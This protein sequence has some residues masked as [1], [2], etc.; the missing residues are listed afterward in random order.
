MLQTF[1]TVQHDLS[2]GYEKYYRGILED[3]DV[4][5]GSEWASEM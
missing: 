2:L 3:S 5:V 1:N 4:A